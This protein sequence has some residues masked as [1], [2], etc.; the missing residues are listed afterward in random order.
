MTDVV[1]TLPDSLRVELKSPAGPLYTDP[2]GLL[3]DATEPLVTVGDVVTHH[4]LGAG[5]VPKAALVDERTERSAV[6][7]AVRERIEG[8]SFTHERTVTNPPAGL[9]AELL[10]TLPRL[11]AVD[12]EEDLATLPAV[13][14]A[15]PGAS[16]V[17]GQPGE[18]MVL[19]PA[20][21]SHSSRMRDLL[22][23]MD[24]DPDRLFEL[25]G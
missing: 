7:P 9:S 24:G 5:T 16:V 2:E 19:V 4:V 25:L 18:G 15:P 6:D 20:D 11:F 3:A 10:E 1:V 21:E 12:G 8:S 22:A 17:Y 23:R 14:V 13:L